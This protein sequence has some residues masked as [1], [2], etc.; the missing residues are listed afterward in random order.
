MLKNIAEYVLTADRLS[1]TEWPDMVLD[2]AESNPQP[3]IQRLLVAL[4]ITPCGCCFSS[5]ALVLH[6]HVVRSSDQHAL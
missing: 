6:V 4:P 5:L 2:N 1:S 3:R